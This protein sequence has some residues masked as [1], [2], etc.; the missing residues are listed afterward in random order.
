[1]TGHNP[2]LLEH[3]H[4]IKVLLHLRKNFPMPLMELQGAIDVNRSALERRIRELSEAGMIKIEVLKN[5]KRRVIV[6]LTPFGREVA[7]RLAQTDRLG[8]IAHHP[9]TSNELN[10]SDHSADDFIRP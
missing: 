6:S 9:M 2:N 5:M 10:D 3:P 8:G 7:N 1:M 4:A